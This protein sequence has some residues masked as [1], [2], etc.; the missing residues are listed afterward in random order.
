MSFRV[1]INQKRDWELCPI[2]EVLEASKAPFLKLS[3]A[4]A[5]CRPQE[6]AVTLIRAGIV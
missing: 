3:Q 5:M 1:T 4:I 2:L 6:I